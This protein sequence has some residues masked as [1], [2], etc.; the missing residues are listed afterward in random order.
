MLDTSNHHAIHLIITSDGSYQD[1]LD[2]I[3]RQLLKLNCFVQGDDLQSGFIVEIEKTKAVS[4]LK[5]LIKEKKASFLKDVDASHLDLFHVSLVPKDGDV[6]TVFQNAN[7]E[8]LDTFLPLSQVF[9]WRVEDNLH[10]DHSIHIVVRVRI[11]PREYSHFWFVAAFTDVVYFS[12]RCKLQ[13][14]IHSM[15]LNLRAMKRKRDA[16]R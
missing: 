5:D 13:P 7:I 11:P 12:H 16:D 3:P 1:V 8:P 2:L 15:T 4:N 14:S 9:L 6:N 10:L